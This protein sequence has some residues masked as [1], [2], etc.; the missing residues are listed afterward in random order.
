V[1]RAFL[2]VD[3]PVR[4]GSARNA[5]TTTQ[6]VRAIIEESMAAA[7]VSGNSS[8]LVRVHRALLALT[9]VVEGM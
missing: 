4:N 5:M 8:E 7:K 3:L 6:D 1:G 9:S 2:A